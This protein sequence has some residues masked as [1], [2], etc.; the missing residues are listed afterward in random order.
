MK[1][2]SSKPPHVLSDILKTILL[3]ICFFV[4][5]PL[6]MAIAKINNAS[7]FIQHIIPVIGMLICFAIALI[8]TEKH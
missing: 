5:I 6:A 3:I 4:I 2:I 8:R 7:H 1:V